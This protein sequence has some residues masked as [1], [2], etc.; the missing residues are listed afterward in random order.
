MCAQSSKSAA[1]VGRI[2]TP[3]G[4]IDTPGFV[5]VG[6]NAALKAVDSSWADAGLAPAAIDV[7]GGTRLPLGRASFLGVARCLSCR[8]PA[9]SHLTRLHP[10]AVP[11]CS[12]LPL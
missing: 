4:V 2:H 8:H 9:A 3:H 7:C 12:L 6:T 11:M 10:M 5:A 1:R